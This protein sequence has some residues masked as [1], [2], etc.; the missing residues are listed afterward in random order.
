[1]PPK[2]YA[3]LDERTWALIAKD[4]EAHAGESYLVFGEVTQFD[5]ATG[6]S[7]FRANVAAANTCE[8]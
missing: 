6:T 7:A 3:T 1:M 4:P 8:Y 5:S 2:E